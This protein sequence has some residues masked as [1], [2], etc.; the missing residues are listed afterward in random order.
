MCTTSHYPVYQNSITN[1]CKKVLM[2]SVLTNHWKIQYVEKYFSV[3]LLLYQLKVFVRHFTYIDWT[4]HVFC[5]HNS[6]TRSS[7]NFGNEQSTT[8]KHKRWHS[9]LNLC[10]HTFQHHLFFQIFNSLLKD[11]TFCFHYYALSLKVIYVTVT[12]P[13]TP[14]L[15]F[16]TV[17][18]YQ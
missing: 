10:C 15:T 13:F 2:E 1:Q 17:P 16:L 4:K 9:E 11:T 5:D 18:S 6:T 7:P 14:L 8:L 12:G 3:R